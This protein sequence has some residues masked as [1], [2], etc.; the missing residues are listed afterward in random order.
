MYGNKY[1]HEFLLECKRVLVSNGLLSFSGHD[2]R[3]EMDNYK[4]YMKERKFYPYVDTELYWETFES[5]E[6][7]NF[8]KGAGYTVVVCEKGEIYNKEDGTILHCL[9]RK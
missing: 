1:K 8:A 5:N 4:K 2:F 9:C 3:F 7:L 6:L